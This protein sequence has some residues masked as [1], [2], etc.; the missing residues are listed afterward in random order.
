[1]D[2][3]TESTNDGILSGW[4]KIAQRNPLITP[5]IG[6]T[7]YNKRHFSGTTSLLNPQVKYTSRTGL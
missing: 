3:P 7:A 2:I 1:M 6:F 5:T 4:P